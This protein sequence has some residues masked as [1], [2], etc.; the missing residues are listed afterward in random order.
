MLMFIFGVMFS[1]VGFLLLIN[2]SKRSGGVGGGFMSVGWKNVII[3]LQRNKL[4][5]L[6]VVKGDGKLKNDF[7]WLDD[8]L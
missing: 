6:V 8:V 7:K 4:W 1:G 5:V 2:G 3:I